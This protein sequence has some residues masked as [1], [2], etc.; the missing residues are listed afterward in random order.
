MGG[1]SNESTHPHT[2]QEETGDWVVVDNEAKAGQHSDKPYA[3]PAVDTPGS[4][5]T[6]GNGG[7]S[8]LETSNFDD[9]ANFTNMDSAGDALAAYDDH[10]DLDLP[11]LEN[12]AFGDAFHASDNEMGHHHD[13]DEMS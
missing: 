6:P 3:G 9:A 10:D 1:A 5:L 7:N 4:G 11:D 13:D 12:S 2:A 8:G